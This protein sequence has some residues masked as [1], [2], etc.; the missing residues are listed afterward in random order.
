M[1]SGV[2]AA[3]EVELVQAPEVEPE[4][5]LGP[6]PGQATGP[7]VAREGVETRRPTWYIPPS[8]GR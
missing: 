2:E 7:G 4:L 3:S 5:G 8:C 6:G 1:D